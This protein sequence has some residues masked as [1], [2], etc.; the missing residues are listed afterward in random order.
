VEVAKFFQ[1]FGFIL[2]ITSISQIVFF[3]TGVQIV[4]FTISATWFASAVDNVV[5]IQWCFMFSGRLRQW[6]LGWLGS[7]QSIWQCH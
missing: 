7:Y 2:W 4:F 3:V 1:P 6:F 5:Y